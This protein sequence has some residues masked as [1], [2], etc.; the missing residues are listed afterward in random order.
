MIRRFLAWTRGQRRVVPDY[1]ATWRAA[2]RAVRLRYLEQADALRIEA[3]GLFRRAMQATDFPERHRLY[4]LALAQELR[5]EALHAL[6]GGDA[7]SAAAHTADAEHYAALAGE[8][9]AVEAAHA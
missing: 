3:R 4:S 7:V 5:A 8:P 6:A 9:R 1:A 2:E